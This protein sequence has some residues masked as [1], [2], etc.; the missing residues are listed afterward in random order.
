MERLVLLFREAEMLLNQV[1]RMTFPKSFL[2][3]DFLMQGNFFLQ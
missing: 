2:T 1:I 3:V